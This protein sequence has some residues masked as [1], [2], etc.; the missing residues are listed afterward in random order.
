MMYASSVLKVRKYFFEVEDG[1]YFCGKPLLVG[2]LP[3]NQSCKQGHAM[4]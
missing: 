2:A 1:R 4:W 3:N